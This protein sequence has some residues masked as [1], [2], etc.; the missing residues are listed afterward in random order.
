MEA[1]GTLAGGIAHDF[2]NIL[3]PI[4]IST[5]M[6][7]MSIPQ[8]DPF[9]FHLVQILNASKRARELTRQ[10]L[11]FSRHSEGKKIALK[12][13]VIVKEA[14]KMLR[15]SI[16]ATI[17]IKQII[18]FKNDIIYANPTQIHQILMNL[19]TNAAQAMKEKGGI[20]RV[21][22]T[23]VLIN[24][25]QARRNSDFPAGGYVRLLVS[26]TGKGMAKEIVNRIFDPYFTTKSRGEGTG[27][28]LSVVHGI[29]K[30]HGGSINVVSSSD[31][32]TTFEVLL[33]QVIAAPKAE[34]Q[35]T[36]DYEVAA[37]GEHH[38]LLVDDEEYLLTSLGQALEAIGYR[39][40]RA[41]NGESALDMFRRNPH[42]FALIITDQ[43]MPKMT[44]AKLA[45]NVLKIRPKMPIIICTGF[46]AEFDA[47]AARAIGIKEFILKPLELK[48]LSK[49]IKNV[50]R[51]EGN[52][53][54]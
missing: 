38:I 4:M 48:Q 29:V 15:S 25:E 28:G 31:K 14:L 27:L 39:V 47:A 44:G 53:N 35:E 42:D 37:A 45:E 3:S 1:I 10:I 54:G 49:L 2:N 11:D 21:E 34:L 26:D 5:E 19:C 36:D 20:L 32:G 7:M 22:L 18:N 12:I 13:S 17:E 46:T 50:L 52:K 30:E 24:A 6:L 41:T 23:E 9:Y 16:P 40:T 51:R 8:D 43:T 33:P